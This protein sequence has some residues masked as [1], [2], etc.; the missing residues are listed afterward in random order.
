MGLFGKKKTEEPPVRRDQVLRLIKLGM[1]ETDAAD[2]Y[3]DDDPPKFRKA[4]DRMNAECNKSTQAEI[5]AAYVAL[6][7]HGY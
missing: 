4:R 7:R 2:Q 3:I 6:K 1:Q 5:R